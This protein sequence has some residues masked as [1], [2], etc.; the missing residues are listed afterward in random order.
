MEHGYILDHAWMHER[1]RLRL[2]MAQDAESIRHL[3]R[4]EVRQPEWF[5]LSIGRWRRLRG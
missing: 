4:L 3:E 2:E 1:D 5:G